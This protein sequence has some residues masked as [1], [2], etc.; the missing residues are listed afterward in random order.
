MSATKYLLSDLCQIHVLQGNLHCLPLKFSI[1]KILAQVNPIRTT[2][3]SHQCRNF[4]H[5]ILC[6]IK[7]VALFVDA[8]NRNFHI[9]IYQ[10]PASLSVSP[11]NPGQLYC[12]QSTVY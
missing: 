11:K 10:R 2:C 7:I 9:L 1:I 5:C 3:L 8:E 6:K 12:E 4:N